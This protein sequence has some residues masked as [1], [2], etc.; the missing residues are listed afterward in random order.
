M[1]MYTGTR[2][3]RL[4]STLAVDEA[5]MP[6]PRGKP[7]SP[8]GASVVGLE[9]AVVNNALTSSREGLRGWGCESEAV[10]GWCAYCL[11]HGCGCF[12]SGRRG[13]GGCWRTIVV[14]AVVACRLSSP[15]QE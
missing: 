5:A 9:V 3:G 8:G 12:M 6:E 7:A 11:S 4:A 1:S 2:L 14:K 15:S 13:R 10:E